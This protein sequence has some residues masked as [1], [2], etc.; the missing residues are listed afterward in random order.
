MLGKHKM[1]ELPK[2]GLGKKK[3]KKKQDPISK[4]TRVKRAG[5]VAQAAEHLLT[6]C[7][8]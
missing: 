4:V 8:P 5:G 3:K 7:K 2:D 6:K 1:G